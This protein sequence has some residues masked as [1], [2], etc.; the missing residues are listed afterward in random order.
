MLLRDTDNM[1]M[2]CLQSMNYFKINHLVQK[3]E[4]SS[5]FLFD[6]SM[7]LFSHLETSKAIKTVTKNE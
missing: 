2:N 6:E 1:I 5:N 7:L 3:Y 4:K